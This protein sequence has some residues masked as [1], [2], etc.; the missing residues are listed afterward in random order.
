MVHWIVVW[1]FGSD[2]GRKIGEGAERD[3][4]SGTGVGVVKGDVGG[5]GGDGSG[6]VA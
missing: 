4:G 3:T 1:S 2:R 5:I 6:E